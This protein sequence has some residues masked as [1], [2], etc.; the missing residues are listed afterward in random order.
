[1][2]RQRK[3]G[4][5]AYDVHTMA[6]F[7]DAQETA[8][9]YGKHI[10]D[11]QELFRASEVSFGSPED[12]FR[13]APMLARDSSFRDEFTA[14]VKSIQQQE[15]GQLALTTM[16][17]MVGVASGGTEIAKIG[18]EGAVPV[19][20]LVVFLAG[21]GGWEETRALE[22]AAAG[23]PETELEQRLAADPKEDVVTVATSL[24]GGPKQVK[25]ALS[26]LEMNTLQM[27]MHLD[28]IDSRMERLAPNAS[29]GK[30]RFS[31]RPVE[32]PDE[33]SDERDG[34]SLEESEV[35][36]SVPVPPMKPWP[37]A[38]EDAPRPEWMASAPPM[39]PWPTQKDR[40]LDWKRGAGENGAP[41]RANWP[42]KE[43]EPVWKEP[44]RQSEPVRET[45]PAG[46]RT[47]A[48]GAAPLRWRPEFT[49]E[50]DELPIRVP[51]EEYLE[52][53]HG[54]RWRRGLAAVLGV[55]VI[56]AAVAG[57]ML[58]RARGWQGIRDAAHTAGVALASGKARVAGW[59]GT[60]QKATS[61]A[62]VTSASAQSPLS[63]AAHAATA[64]GPA[65]TTVP[66]QT[67]APT[68]TAEPVQAAKTTTS[69]ATPLPKPQDLSAAAP[70]REHESEQPSPDAARGVV[71]VL[72]GSGA[73][74][75][76]SSPSTLPKGMHSSVPVFVD[77]ARLSALSSPRPDYPR[78]AL[79]RGITGDVVVQA[80]IGR[81]G[82]VES[83]QI[84]S[85]PAG[86]LKSS[87]D[88][89]KQWRFRPYLMQG[90]AVECRT[91]IR[92]RYSTAE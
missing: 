61:V 11:F 21:I 31:A 72:A 75:D 49:A 35:I 13:L 9:Q 23:K 44:M 46:A 18:D 34:D 76:E 70:A 62:P 64:T 45:S 65:E 55:L 59:I 92:F 4:D 38:G 48:S 60:Q 80:N 25:E 88:A 71:S 85:G 57:G 37:T 83:T 73:A 84:V 5:A 17:T 28:S 54:S 91:Y 51:F 42:V 67:S 63:T 90:A 78:D 33:R 32:R 36:E 20:L 6:F 27:K 14:Q 3:R 86:L 7:S 56:A 41:P 74:S 82:E 77:E 22:S 16:L 1:M 66:A 53:E 2:T 81:N 26:R 43:A 68:P 79:A 89:A 29:D 8:R 10:T 24:F 50:D 12:F 52:E 87:L 30:A 47:L 40:E 69:V 39:R 58:D 15:D 19:S